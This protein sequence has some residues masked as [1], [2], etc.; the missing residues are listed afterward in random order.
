AVKHTLR[1]EVPGAR[2]ADI[3]PVGIA[4]TRDGRRAFVGLGRANH[5]AFV[6][7]RTRK[8]T[9]LVL[10]G[11]RAW[12][13]A[14]DKAEAR[15]YVVNGLSDDMTVIDVVAAKALKTVPVGRVPYQ[16]VVIE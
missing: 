8:M 2:A 12:N 4:M 3:T 10:A 5:V 15:L 14:L 1:F 11:K 16:A 6:D 13:V 9:H 7:V